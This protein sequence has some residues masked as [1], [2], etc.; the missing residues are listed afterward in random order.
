MSFS[1]PF[2]QNPYFQMPNDGK[3]LYGAPQDYSGAPIVSGPTGYLEGNP[4]AAYT[5][6]ISGFGGGM[7]NFSRFVQQQYNKMRGGYEAA[8]ATNPDL[9]FQN[10]LQPF[11]MPFF[12]N[13]FN[14]GTMAQRG[15]RP[16]NFAGRAR[17]QSN[18]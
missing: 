4:E 9:T 8:A 2:G 10:Y 15:E 7:D 18:G 14:A 12:Q 17:W 6:H 11:G 1:N 3:N 5:R 13:L 16:E